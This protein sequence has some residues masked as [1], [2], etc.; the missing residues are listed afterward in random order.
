MHH[1]ISNIYKT[2]NLQKYID[3]RKGDKCIGLKSVTYGIGWYNINDENI[4]K[5]G[6]SPI[7]IPNGYYSFQQLSNF[8][9]KNN[10]TL[11]VNETNGI[12]TL[13]TTIEIKISKGLKEI[14]G[15]DN[16]RKLEANEIHIGNKCL[17]LAIYKSLYVHLEQISTYYNYFNGTPSTI[18][19]VIPI[20]NKEFG[21]II[22]MRLEHPEYKR[23]IND[24]IT[25]FKL[26]LRD[27]NN[28]KID[29]NLSVSCVLEIIP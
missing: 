10:I 4:Q 17:D 9:K 1:T 2:I 25:E 6:E 11:S 12:A 21:E 14:L 29:N 16:K 19:A 13:T 7:Q 8:L 18:L 27:E 23:L 24:T 3:N 26:E 22:T 28:K 20:E 15:F 5:K